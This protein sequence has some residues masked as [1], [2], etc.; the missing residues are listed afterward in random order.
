MAAMVGGLAKNM[1]YNREFFTDNM[2]MNDNVL[3]S[4]AET[5]VST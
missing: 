4:C 5:G 3:K 2:A 1:K